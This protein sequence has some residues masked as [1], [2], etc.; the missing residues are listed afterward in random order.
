LPGGQEPEW[1]NTA[2][3]KKLIKEERNAAAFINLIKDDG[4]TAALKK[5]QKNDRRLLKQHEN[6]SCI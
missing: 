2:A 6:N 4:N 3:L 1:R 5:N